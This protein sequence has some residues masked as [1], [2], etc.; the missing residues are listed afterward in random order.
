MITNN[1]NNTNNTHIPSIVYPMSFPFTSMPTQFE[2]FTSSNDADSQSFDLNI[3]NYS[4]ED[5]FSIYKIRK[6]EQ[7][8]VTEEYIK[9]ST[10]EIIKNYY[11]VNN[12]NGSSRDIPDDYVNF[13]NNAKTRLI[14]HLQSGSAFIN[15]SSVYHEQYTT[16]SNTQTHQKQQYSENTLIGGEQNVML[17]RNESFQ[18]SVNYEYPKGIINPIER[19]LLKRVI[20]ID[21]LFRANYDK[22]KSTDFTWTLPAPINNVLS[23]QIVTTQIPNMIRTFSTAKTNNVFT[24]NLYNVKQTNTSNTISHSEVITIPQGVYMTDVFIKS[25]NNYFVNASPPTGGN[26]SGLKFLYI[27][28]NEKTTNTVIRSR[29]QSDIDYENASYAFKTTD[30]NYSPNFYFSVDFN[31]PEDKSFTDYYRVGGVQYRSIPYDL[32]GVECSSASFQRTHMN[33]KNINCFRPNIN[34][35]DGTFIRSPTIKMRPLYKN[36]GWMMGFRKDFYDTSGNSPFTAYTATSTNNSVVTYNRY[37]NSEST[38]GNAIIQYFYVEIDDF[39]RNFTSNTIMAE[40]GNGTYLGNN[41]VARIPITSGVYAISDSNP[42]DLIYKR[43][44]YFGPV[45]IEK[46]NIRLLDKFG[47]VL[48]IIDNDYS[49][50]IELTTMY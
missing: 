39:N 10:G 46:V 5:L 23:L 22:T 17:K 21:T 15:D 26:F 20:C 43:R 24:I 30:A 36:A 35:L 7:A 27:E 34:P 49:L 41:I 18:N 42:S 14:Q 50:A 2:Q 11:S 40:T 9:K 6:Q 8:N 32:S 28:I 25:M 33:S 29:E 19:R 4:I 12:I 13:F 31:I 38:Y 3:D 45:K 16:N 37:I 44:D 1:T 48:D 47:E